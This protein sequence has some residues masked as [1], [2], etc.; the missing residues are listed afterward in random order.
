MQ[1][2]AGTQARSLG[3]PGGADISLV[4]GRSSQAP[5]GWPCGTF[6]FPSLILSPSRQCLET[7]FCMWF[8]GPFGGA[9]KTRKCQHRVPR[10]AWL[11]AALVPSAQAG[12]QSRLALLTSGGG[13]RM[14]FPLPAPPPGSLMAR[15]P[16]KLLGTQCP[17]LLSGIADR[18]KLWVPRACP[19]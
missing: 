18:M 19:G 9:D 10:S 14:A 1:P 12:D 16:L 13:A 15:L 3:L 4:A 6:P 5:G 8:P 17:G 11:H 2:A 7:L